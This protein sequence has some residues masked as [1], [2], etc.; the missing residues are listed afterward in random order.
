VV[1]D[2]RSPECLD[3]LFSTEK[4]NIVFHAA[5]LK[6]VP[7]LEDPHNMVEA[8]LTNIYGT[9]NVVR[10]VHDQPKCVFVNVSTD[11]AVNPSSILGLTKRAAELMVRSHVAR[12]G[13]T[14]A[15]V[16]F[17]NVI[18]SVGSV[19]PLFRRQ[20]ASGGPVT[21]TDEAATRYFMTIAHEKKHE[22]GKMQ[23]GIHALEDVSAL[24]DY[25]EL[26]MLEGLILQRRANAS[27]RQLQKLIPQYNGGFVA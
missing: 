22:I 26:G 4:P 14:A 27:A 7:M 11:K 9:L 5:A 18:D 13:T 24:P 21:I 10:V 19:I 20:I 1:G 17:G 23:A 2:V 16:R 8:C 25:H 15:S 6:H 12:Y 3:Q